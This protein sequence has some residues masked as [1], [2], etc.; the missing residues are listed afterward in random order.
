MHGASGHLHR[1]LDAILKE[2][3]RVAGVGADKPHVAVPLRCLQLGHCR[4]GGGVDHGPLEAKVGDDVALGRLDDGVP[5]LEEG[6][7]QLRAQI[8]VDAIHP[9]G[10]RR[11]LRLRLRHNVQWRPVAGVR[12][13]QL[14]VGVQHDALRLVLE[15]AE[16]VELSGGSGERGRVRLRELGPFD[17]ELGLAGVG[18]G[19]RRRRRLRVRHGPARH[20]ACAAPCRWRWP[21]SRGQSRQRSRCARGRRHRAS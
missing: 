21:A 6:P 13:H 16:G 3:H 9:N 14:L 17:L 2:R 18:V 12:R 15:A 19:G 20:A 10:Y 5:R 8:G 4:D 11:R 7:A 1:R